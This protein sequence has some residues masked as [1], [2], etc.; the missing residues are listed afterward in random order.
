MTPF[1]WACCTPSQTA[2]KSSR[3]CAHAERVAVAVGADRLAVDVLHDEERQAVVGGAGV[4]HLRDAGVVHPRQRLALG[5]E[6]R[7][8]PRASPCRGADELDRHQPPDRLA[9]LG[10]V[11]GAHAPLAE[12]VEDPVG[13]DVL[14]SGLEP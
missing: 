14:A 9:L 3:R 8:R 4:E 12:G 7:Q 11:D 1:W 10:E 13:A 2:M 6:A 5:L